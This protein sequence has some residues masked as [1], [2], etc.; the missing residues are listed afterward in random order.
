[1]IVLVLSC[2]TDAGEIMLQTRRVSNV[3]G[4]Y[5]R[6]NPTFD[7]A[8]TALIVID[9]WDA[10][11]VPFI[12]NLKECL[13]P[14]IEI[15]R[16]EKILVIYAAHGVKVSPI[17]TPR[18]GDYV[19]PKDYSS[20]SLR[21]FLRRKGITDLWYAGYATNMC[22]LTRPSGIV[23]MYKDFKVVLFRDCTFAVEAAHSRTQE[24]AKKGAITMIELTFGATSTLGELKG[25]WR[26]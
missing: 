22:L 5:I 1:M 16:K 13:L 3:D 14:L 6:E 18:N 21:L 2:A 9:P 20:D 26:K 23:H 12:K 8:K 11:D 24:E 25:A 15:C 10:T 19:L 4:N 7:T 17:V